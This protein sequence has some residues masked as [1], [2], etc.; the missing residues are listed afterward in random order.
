METITLNR[1]EY[2]NLRHCPFCGSGTN[3]FSD[4]NERCPHLVASFENGVWGHD[5]CPPVTCDWYLFEDSLE[6]FVQADHLV[7]CKTTPRTRRHPS[8]KA[9]Y[10]PDSVFVAELRMQFKIEPV[11]A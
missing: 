10:H 11:V 7:I 4:E 9:Y 2:D 3:L 1:Y 5:L 6:E 8:I